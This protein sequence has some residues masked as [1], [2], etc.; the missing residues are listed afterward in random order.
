MKEC[1]EVHTP[2]SRSGV[3][4]I[5]NGDELGEEDSRRVRRAI[6]RVSYMSQDRADLSV[7]ARVMSQHMARPRAG[8]VPVVKR[9]IRYLKKY[10]RCILEIPAGEEPLSVVEVLTD[11]DWANDPVSR[12]SCSG[13]LVQLNGVTICHWS[14]TQQN[15]A[16]SSGEAE[17]NAAVKGLSEGIAVVEL[18]RETVSCGLPALSFSLCVDASACRGI[19]LR[20]GTWKIKRLA[21]KQLWVQGAIESYGVVVKKTPRSVNSADFLTHA[22]SPPDLVKHLAGMGFV[23]GSSLCGRG[24]REAEGGCRE[25]TPTQRS[26]MIS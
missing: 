19:L 12:R 17:L 20:Q 16:L 21:T 6:A 22:C 23:F 18:L 8:V 3:D 15:V 11:S 14:K 9:V 2:L 5:E 4:E 25:I 10:P 13:G 1:R 24:S 26:M 7:A